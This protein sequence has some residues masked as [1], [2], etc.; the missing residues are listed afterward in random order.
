MR[1]YYVDHA[2]DVLRIF[3]NYHFPIQ[4]CHHNHTECDQPATDGGGFF[5]RAFAAGESRRAK[6]RD[7]IEKHNQRTGNYVKCY[8]GIEYIFQ[9]CFRRRVTNSGTPWQKHERRTNP[10]ERGI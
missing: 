8:P 10:V 6:R 7:G 1:N 4:Y 9:I 5:D 2:F 3:D